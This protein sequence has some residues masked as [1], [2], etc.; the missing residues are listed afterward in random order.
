MKIAIVA[1]GTGGHIY[2]GLAIAEEVRLRDPKAEILF[3]GSEEGLEKDLVSRAGYEIK[4]IKSRAL[5]RKLSYK[6]ISAPFVSVIGF[7]QALSILKANA[8]TV[9]FSTGGYASLPVVLTARLLGIPILLHEQNV[10]PGAVNRFC[11]RFSKLNFLSFPQSLEYMRGE[12]VGNPVR[13]KILAGQKDQACKKLKL[14]KNKKVVLVMGG[15]QGAKSINQTVL[16]ALSSLPAGVQIIHLIGKRDFDWAE[17]SF[18][19]FPNYFPFAYL[20]DMQ[21]VLAAADLVISRAG[22]T[23]IFEFLA[24]GLPMVLIPF[25]YAAGNHQLLNAQAIA[26]NGAAVVVNDQDFTANKFIELL[27]S[28]VLDY[29]KMRQASL[30]LAKP[31]AAQRIVDFIYA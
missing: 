11:Q 4:L 15:S 28:S 31:Q 12:V 30:S 5:L 23:A 10:L 1:G 7:F 20:D 27:S 26:K 17:H 21:D 3:L 19:N 14:D 24:K 29:D 8:P 25:P 22:A 18:K 2:P 13:R 6:A 9:L 16:A